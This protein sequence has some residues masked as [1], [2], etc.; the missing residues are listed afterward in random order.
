MA[1]RRRRRGRAKIS[2]AVLALRL[3]HQLTKDEILALYLTLAP[4]GNQ[5]E[6]AERAAQAYFGR[7]AATLTPAEAAFLAAL[8]QQPTRFNPW[9]D[10]KPRARRARQRILARH[11]RSRAGS[12]AADYD[13]ARHEALALSRESRGAIA[14]H[15]VERVLAETPAARPRR[16]DT[17]LDATLQRDG[18]G[19]HRRRPRRRSRGIVRT[20]SRSSCSTT[21]PASGWRGKDRATTSISEHGG[22]I[23]GVVAPRQPGSALKPFTYAAAFE[24]GYHPGR[25]LADVPSQFPTAEPGV[26][27]SPRNY[28]G[29]FRGP[30][31]ARAALA[32]SEN[33]PAVALASDIGVPAV[34]S[35]AAAMPGFTT[36][37][38]NAAHYGLG[39]TLGN[40]EVRLDETGGR[41]FDV[42]ARR[43]VCRADAAIRADRRRPAGRRRR[44]A[45][46]AG[47]PS[48]TAFWI[49][50][51]LSDAEAR[52]F[53]F[54]RGGSLEFPFTVAAKTGTSQAYHDNWAIGYTRDVTVGVWVG[55]FDRT[56]LRGFIGG[57]RRGPDL[58]RRHARRRRARQRIPADRRVHADRGPTAD[59]ERATLCAVSGLTA[60]GACPRRVTE[61]VPAG[62]PIADCTWHHA[63]DHGVLTVWPEPYRHW[64][65][66]AGLLNDITPLAAAQAIKATA[67][68]PVAGGPDR[69]STDRRTLSIVAPLAGAVYLFDPTLRAEFQTLPL[70]AQGATGQ[71]EWFINQTSI[72]R[73]RGDETMRW[74]ISR[75]NTKSPSRTPPDTRRRRRL[76]SDSAVPCQRISRPCFRIQRSASRHQPQT[77]ATSRQKRREWLGWRTCI[78]SW[79][80]M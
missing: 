34:A 2:E 13:T 66:T 26:L 56:P 54:G 33:V 28:D 72:G 64:A 53:V 43:R 52:A 39:L 58:S 67:A 10:P 5:I 69:A 11:A 80:R 74:P 31:L 19:H 23:D 20:T 70:R 8:P 25:V 49:T 61:W 75:G 16:I 79:N 47:S 9:R 17:T 51:I 44:R 71:L 42:R 7:S 46:R 48:A 50:D 21:G 27:Y 77:D 73:T 4:Y 24:R 55:N 1:R 78:S 40:A 14:P 35:P 45:T 62:A 63:S 18:A 37:D 22:A 6:G 3:E 59:V 60:T 36:L 29:Q 76:S 15:F 32:G 68:A 57:H 65:R 41:L 30:L 38:R 12:R